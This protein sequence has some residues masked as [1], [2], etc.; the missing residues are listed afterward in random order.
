MYSL[1]TTE[2]III[3]TA[4]H[5]EA[6]RI[7]TLLTRDLGLIQAVALGCR[8]NCSKLRSTL[9]DLAFIQATLVRGK[10]GWRL[11]TASLERHLYFDLIPVQEKI[12]VAGRFFSLLKRLI[13]GEHPEPVLFDNVS[14]GLRFLAK[15]DFSAEDL[16]SFESILVI[17]LLRV[18][19][20]IADAPALS[21]FY[22]EGF[23]KELLADLRPVR[24]EAF[25]AI[26][27]GLQESH[28]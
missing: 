9:L 15:T 11:T 10:N 17:R 20:Y 2:A 19:G 6:D 27:L 28:L 22:Q 5:R 3:E 25:K 21:P 7:L 1:H 18:L 12:K 26:N 8:N 24:R 23:S 13:R 4:E 14:E 16:I